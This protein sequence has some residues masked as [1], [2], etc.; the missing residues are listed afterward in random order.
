[1]SLNEEQTPPAQGLAAPT[2]R[3]VVEDMHER[4]RMGELKY[5]V[6]HQHD[7]GRDHLVDLYQE[8]LD[9]TC[10]VRAEI[11]KRTVERARAAAMV[12]A[13]AVRHFASGKGDQYD[14]LSSEMLAKN[15]EGQP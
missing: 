6:R 11:E 15:I 3:L 12:R 7:N 10:Y 1:V 14:L 5:G 4:D 2:W 8:L 9:A 13:W